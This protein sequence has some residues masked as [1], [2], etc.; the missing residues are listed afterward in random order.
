[1]VPSTGLVTSSSRRGESRPLSVMLLEARRCFTVSVRIAAA[2]SPLA[3]AA[4]DSL[5][6]KDTT[7]DRSSGCQVQRPAPR[8]QPDHEDHSEALHDP[9]LPERRRQRAVPLLDLAIGALQAAVLLLG[10]FRQA[11]LGLAELSELRDIAEHGDDRERPGIASFPGRPQIGGGD[12]ERARLAIARDFD[13]APLGAGLQR[14][15]VEDK[16]REFV[17]PF[18]RDEELPERAAGSLARLEVQYAFRRRIERLDPAAGPDDQHPVQQ[19]VE[20][21]AMDVGRRHRATCSMLIPH[22]SSVVP[23]V[24]LSESSALR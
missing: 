4:P 14:R 23:S 2:P 17:V 18:A 5:P 9:H 3:A 11:Q 24:R 1:M 20:H 15:G 10:R 6:K 16:L 13:H 21:A 12:G 8:K 19:V 7:T 22:R